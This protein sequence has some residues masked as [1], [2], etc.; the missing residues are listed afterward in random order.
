M[1]SENINNLI[2]EGENE[3]IEFKTSFNNEVIETLVAFANTKGGNVLIGVNSGNQVK[4][5]L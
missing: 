5:I 2:L 3:S 4:G 1:N